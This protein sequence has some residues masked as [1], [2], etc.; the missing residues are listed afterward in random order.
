MLRH[1]PH[2]AGVQVLDH[3]THLGPI[4]C[5]ALLQ[6]VLIA[7]ELKDREVIFGD[8]ICRTVHQL[9]AL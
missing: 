3:G 5:T 6:V 8:D 2:H 7:V 9:H 1:Q 4:I